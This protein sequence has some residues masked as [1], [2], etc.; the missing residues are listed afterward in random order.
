MLNQQE[1]RKLGYV[2]KDTIA[3]NHEVHAAI[4]NIE[5]SAAPVEE[6]VKNMLSVCTYSIV[7]YFNVK[8]DIK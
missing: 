8:I 4:K 3:K 1:S 5:L 2:Y 7:F 6:S